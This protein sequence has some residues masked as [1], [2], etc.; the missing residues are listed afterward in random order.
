[1]KKKS[2]MLILIIGIFTL[3]PLIS[4]IGVK[5]QIFIVKIENKDDSWNYDFTKIENENKDESW[6]YEVK[7]M[8]ILSTNFTTRCRSLSTVYWFDYGWY[9]SHT[10]Y[11][12]TSGPTAIIFMQ[13]EGGSRT[14][15]TMTVKRRSYDTQSETWGNWSTVLSDS[16]G[17]NAA[18]KI[19]D[20][21]YT[22]GTTYAVWGSDNGSNVNVKYSYS[23]TGS[24]WTTTDLG[25]STNLGTGNNIIAV[26]VFEFDTLGKWAMLI[27]LSTGKVVFV[28]LSDGTEIIYSSYGGSYSAGIGYVSGDHYYFPATNSA[29][30]GKYC[31]FNGSSVSESESLP[32]SSMVYSLTHYVGCGL[33][34]KGNVEYLGSF[35]SN[36][37]LFYRRIGTSDWY[38][39]AF[40]ISGRSVPRISWDQENPDQIKY[41]IV[42]KGTAGSFIYETYLLT[43]NGALI[44]FDKKNETDSLVDDLGCGIG[45]EIEGI[46][47]VK[48]DNTN[49][50]NISISQANRY[51]P[52]KLS[53]YDISASVIK[54]DGIVAYLGDNLLFEGNVIDLTYANNDSGKV[55]LKIIYQ[56]L[57]K[58]DLDRAIDADKSYSNKDPS[59]VLN[60]LLPDYCM[61]L[62]KGTVDDSS[63]SY[64]YSF[65]KG[66]K[67]K[68]IIKDCEQSVG[69]MF[70]W[71]ADGKYYFD[72]G[73]QD[74]S[75]GALTLSDSNCGLESMSQKG[76][77]T[78]K[79]IIKGGMDSSK[80]R[81]IGSY[82]NLSSSNIGVTIDTYD[83]G[84]IMTNSNAEAIAQTLYN[85]LNNDIFVYTGVISDITATLETGKK[86]SYSSTANNLSSRD[87]IILSFTEVYNESNLF[88]KQF[89]AIDHVLLT[90]DSSSMQNQIAS[91]SNQITQ[92]ASYGGG[93]SAV[94]DDV[95][96][97]LGGDLETNGHQIILDNNS[98]ILARNA[99]D[100]ANLDV[101][102]LNTY[103][104]VSISQNVDFSGELKN[105]TLNNDMD[106]NS[107]KITDLTDP[108]SNQDAA[109]KKYVDD[110]IPSATPDEVLLPDSSNK[111]IIMLRINELQDNLGSSY[112][113]N[114]MLSGENWSNY[115]TGSDKRLY[116]HLELP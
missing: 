13:A 84:S 51:D 77:Y 7:N 36:Y 76:T 47:I 71:D 17:S 22:T 101:I 102:K 97:E 9:A 25:A 38:Q 19:L 100:T 11:K 75:D 12:Y 35:N 93:I 28:K 96:P 52:R 115:D 88:V 70:H 10:E 29:M 110:N 62:Y 44:K 56:E 34:R 2:F 3:E 27:D 26:D 37:K 67:I 46:E 23:Q 108:T 65:G 63:K 66:T 1:M 78:T 53:L 41:L 50:T 5:Q 91:N 42:S 87:L 89:I 24:S 92:V 99:A 94:V 40:T 64:T 98:A 60:D 57:S 21:S 48:T 73:D 112:R 16:N 61:F 116:L 105:I 31:D 107:H 86:V 55:V 95:S 33:F 109:T 20:G 83:I 113:N 39:I 45:E 111:Q 43:K 18:I 85:L 82:S 81:V 59:Y 30:S 58:S 8:K 4:F 74:L 14:G 103:D 80:H 114:Y 68:N 72:D 15:T 79:V 49:F 106:A 69:K 104:Y 90:P 6:S 54:G 32:S